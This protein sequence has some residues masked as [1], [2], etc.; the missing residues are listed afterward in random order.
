MLLDRSFLRAVEASWVEA[1]SS[2]AA[3]HCQQLK[4]RQGRRQA[5]APPGSK[6]PRPLLFCLEG[7]LRRR[8]GRPAGR[9]RGVAGLPEP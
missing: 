2:H 9:V 5:T 7:L 6:K 1:A 3:S 8:Y 4:A